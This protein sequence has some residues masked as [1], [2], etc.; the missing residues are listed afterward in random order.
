MRYL[1][2]VSGT[3]I[4]LALISGCDISQRITALRTFGAHPVVDRST[5]MDSTK[6]DML[7]IQAPTKITSI[8]GGTSQCFDYALERDGKKADYFV[9]FTS[10]GWANAW[11]YSTCSK[12][13]ADGSLASN[14]RVK[15]NADR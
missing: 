3:V 11:G 13:L 12:V 5:S 14:A 6:Q 10:D 4:A 7:S 9:S 1:L 15:R 2:A 8:R